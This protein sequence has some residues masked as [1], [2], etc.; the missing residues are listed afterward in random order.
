MFVP[1]LHTYFEVCISF[2]PPSA[3]IL[4]SSETIWSSGITID[5]LLTAVELSKPGFS[6]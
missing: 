2:V 1:S 4:F 6:F 5:G 3:R